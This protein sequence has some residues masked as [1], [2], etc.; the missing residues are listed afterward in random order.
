[1]DTKRIN[2]D[3]KS[4]LQ[5][6]SIGLVVEKKFFDLAKENKDLY[7]FAPY[8]VYKEYGIHLD[9]MD[10]N[11]MYEELVANPNV[12]KRIVMSAR[13]MLTRIA[14]VQLESGY[15]YLMFKTNANEFHALKD[16]GQIKIS[17]LC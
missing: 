2:A 6:L 1:M 13:D 10:M 7:V 8:S 17:N 9:D 15:P 12:K 4:R 14:T 3:E 16:I 5:T 11:E